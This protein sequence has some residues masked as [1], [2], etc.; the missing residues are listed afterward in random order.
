MLL[1]YSRFSFSSPFHWTRAIIW[2]MGCRPMLFSGQDRIT[3]VFKISRLKLIRD[4]P[5]PYLIFC[6]FLLLQEPVDPN[7]EGTLLLQSSSK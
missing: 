1:F 6:I 3:R 7:T 5:Y 2:S 4:K